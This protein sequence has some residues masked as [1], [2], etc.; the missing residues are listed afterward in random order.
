MQV[1]GC[2]FIGCA[3]GIFAKG[4][5]FGR[6]LGEELRNFPHSPGR[7]SSQEVLTED[8][9]LILT[10]RGIPELFPTRQRKPGTSQISSTNGCWQSN[11]FEP[12]FCITKLARRNCFGLRITNLE[13]EVLQSGFGVNFYFGLADFR[14]IA[15]GKNFSANFSSN[16]DGEFLWPC[17]SRASDPPK[18][19]M[20][21]I[22]AQTC[23]HSSPFSLSR[24][25]ILLTL[26]F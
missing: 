23:R 21:K 15:G 19:F 2:C 18:K 17:S 26:N 7:V 9:G 6:Y 20:P 24:T 16:F 25:Q 11:R 10:M 4:I 3:E 13:P 8:R 1:A 5:F 14:K 12:R 22:H